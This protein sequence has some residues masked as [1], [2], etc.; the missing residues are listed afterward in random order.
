MVIK[1]AWNYTI[2]LWLTCKQRK[3]FISSIINISNSSNSSCISWENSCTY[4]FLQRWYYPHKHINN[5]NQ[6]VI[7]FNAMKFPVIAISWTSNLAHNDGQMNVKFFPLTVV[8]S[9]W[10][11]PSSGQWQWSVKSHHFSFKM[12]VAKLSDSWS[13]DQAS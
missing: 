11:C 6:D 5:Y 1:W 2:I 10:T 4:S 12:T 7:F 3:K 9:R 8:L 13:S